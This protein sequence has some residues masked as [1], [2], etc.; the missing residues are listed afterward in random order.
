MKRILFIA[1]IPNFLLSFLENNFKILH[2]IGYEVHVATNLNCERKKEFLDFIKI[3]HID[4]QRS[5]LDKLNIKALKQICNVIKEEKIDIIDC[6][7]PMGGILGRLA[8]RKTNTFCIYTAHGFH[9]FKGNNSIKNFIFKNIERFAARYTDI[10]ITINKEDYEAAKNFKLRKNGKVEYIPGVGIDTHKIN[11]IQGSKEK[12]CKELNLVSDSLLLL[13]VG[14]LNDNKNHKI[15]I[16]ILP[17]LPNN[18]HYIICGTGP[19]KEQY[20]QLAKELHVEDRLHLLGY[21]TDVIRIMKSCDIFVFPSKREGLS[22]AL[23]EAMACGLPCVASNIRGNTDL[24]ENEINSFTCNPNNKNQFKNA[25][26]K[27]C[28]QPIIMKKFGE[29]NYCK[30]KK[31]DVQNE[32]MNRLKKIYMEVTKY[33]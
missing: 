5:P 14:E 2:S 15:V 28:E 20:E 32:V 10:I 27:F 17:E 3:H 9:F 21:R 30:S 23:M 19:L 18:V 16:E 22:V 1:T 25:I 26:I 24:I 31:Y 13:S 8:T 6:H 7:T 12:I 4:I 29:I 11:S 33:E